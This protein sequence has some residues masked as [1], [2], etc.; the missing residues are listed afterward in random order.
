MPVLKASKDS[1]RV[2]YYYRTS[3]IGNP[4]LEYSKGTAFNGTWT[5]YTEGTNLSDWKSRI[6]NS[7][8]ATTTFF[9]QKLKA[10]FNEGGYTIVF[11]ENV[12]P[13]GNQL[14]TYLFD[15]MSQ[16]NVPVFI[17]QIGFD[18][19]AENAALI[20]LY[21]RI[22]E[23]HRSFQGLVFLGEM[24][25]TIRMV[26]GR[27]RSLASGITDYISALKKRSKGVPFTKRGNIR[28]KKILADT[29]LEY[30]FGWKPLVSDIEGAVKVIADRQLREE[31][32][33]VRRERVRGIGSTTVVNQ[34]HIP[35]MIDVWPGH[36]YVNAVNRQLQTYTVRY[37]ARMKYT[38]PLPQEEAKAMLAQSGFTLLEF[39]P[40]AWELLPW[41]F[42]V[43]Y[44]SN[45]G[46]FLD[47]F[48]T[49]LDNVYSVTKTVR[50]ESINTYKYSLARERIVKLP[51]FVSLL[52][53]A[54]GCGNWKS[55]YT[56]VDRTSIP[57]TSLPLPR[58]QMENPFSVN[59]TNR[60]LNMTA[61]AAGARPLK[62]FYR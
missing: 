48:T 44:F 26:R 34:T 14:R 24:R 29:W 3:D 1:V 50:Q 39:I 49:P 51:G 58:L 19:S 16:G 61:L 59:A 56:R 17:G 36:V 21:R 46:D 2:P 37:I 31:G 5:S 38:T 60:F 30:S 45:V 15:G 12:N 53:D 40:T 10:E 41:S 28:R 43:D 8:D 25:E 13:F 18:Q 35:E 11:N 20:Q 47:A 54:N 7:Q 23:Q 33:D 6:K 55:T 9:G 4:E 62:P 22:K 42:L 52:E 57:P 27:A 32:L